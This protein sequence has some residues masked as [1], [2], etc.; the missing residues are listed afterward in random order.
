MAQRKC[1]SR[2]SKETQD[3]SIRLFGYRL[4]DASFLDEV[5]HLV[6]EAVKQRSELEL[7]VVKSIKEVLGDEGREI[8]KKKKSDPETIRRNVE[9]CNRRKED[10]KY[11]SHKKLAKEFDVTDGYVRRVLREE[12]KWRKLSENLP[13][14]SKTHRSGWYADQQVQTKTGTN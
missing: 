9:I 5:L 10:R 13:E 4:V 6:K 8:R 7:D 1:F 12:Q 14:E 11:W 3:H 2:D